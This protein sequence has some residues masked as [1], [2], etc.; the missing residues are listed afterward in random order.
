MKFLKN[1]KGVAL[2]TSLL[3]SMLLLTIII[4]MFYMVI[5]STKLSGLQKGYHNA[6]DAAVGG[7]EVATVEALPKLLD[8]ALFPEAGQGLQTRL[9]L[10]MPDLDQDNLL[11][12]SSDVCLTAKLT[13]K[14]WGA[15]CGTGANADASKSLNARVSPDMLFMLRSSI[16]AG[17]DGSKN[18]QGYRVFVKIVSTTPGSSD[19]S[20]RD[21]DASATYEAPPSDVGSPYLYRMEVSSNRNNNAAEQ[22]NLSVLYAY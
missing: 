10:G 15:A 18:A 7:V 16:P 9:L 17:A 19:T 5:Q 12:M 14:N 13:T 1:N 20:G 8:Y 21:L 2:V 3:L 4:A 11:Q 22:A 6:L